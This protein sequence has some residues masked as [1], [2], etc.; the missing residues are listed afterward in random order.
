MPNTVPLLY[1]G[2]KKELQGK[3]CLLIIQRKG[4]PSQAGVLR[5]F[6]SKFIQ[7]IHNKTTLRNIFQNF[8]LHANRD[9]PKYRPTLFV[10]PVKFKPSAKA[11][12]RFDS[13]VHFRWEFLAS[14]FS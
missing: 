3:R 7:S 1:P 5:K 2:L 14:N 8:S 11:V 13:L 4:S 9:T 10:C 6:G 12:F